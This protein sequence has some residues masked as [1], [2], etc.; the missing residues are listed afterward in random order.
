MVRHRTAKRPRER[1]GRVRRTTTSGSDATRRSRTAPQ[2]HSRGDS[3]RRM[4]QPSSRGTRR[5]WAG[6]AGSSPVPS[7]DACAQVVEQRKQDALRLE[8]AS[9]GLETDPLLLALARAAAQERPRCHTRPRR[10]RPVGEVAAERRNRHHLGLEQPGRRPPLVAWDGAGCAA[11]R[12][13]GRPRAA[14]EGRGAAESRRPVRAG[15][16]GTLCRHDGCRMRCGA[17]EG[18]WGASTASVGFGWAGF[19]SCGRC[20]VPGCGTCGEVVVPGSG[21]KSPV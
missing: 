7:D 9:D 12:D 2:S 16:E 14:C 21:R 10:A 11:G 1:R 17:K 8:A 20:R 5:R 6:G 15:P 3:R 18:R 13:Q 4:T 19:G